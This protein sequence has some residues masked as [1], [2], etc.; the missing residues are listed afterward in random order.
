MRQIN[1]ISLVAVLFTSAISWS[2]GQEN[3][4]LEALESR[5]VALEKSVIKDPFHPD[6]TVLSRLRIL[7]DR[8]NAADKIGGQAA[9]TESRE[10]DQ[11]K[12]SLDALMRET[13]ELD[14]RMRRAEDAAR[15]PE[16]P[17]STTE[18][19]DL[20][21]SLSQLT[22]TLDDLQERVRRLEAKR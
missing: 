11:V 19:R 14:Q 5:V 18:L 12:R 17:Q 21:S 2:A 8:L 1:R 4:Q 10:D 6:D 20:R 13:R 15:R 9:K 7:E 3:T 16:N 22:R